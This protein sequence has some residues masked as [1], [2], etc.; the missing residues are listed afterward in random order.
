VPIHAGTLLLAFPHLILPPVEVTSKPAE[1][2]SSPE[3]PQFYRIP[4]S[5]DIALH[6]VPAV[7]L[8]LDFFILERKYSAQQL[9]TQASLLAIAA[10]VSYATWA[11]Y[12]ASKNGACEYSSLLKVF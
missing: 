7:S 5:M 9:K 1:P 6:L 4:L 3:A 10:G 2:S 8:L 12:C 11:E